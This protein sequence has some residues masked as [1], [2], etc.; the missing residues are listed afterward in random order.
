MIYNC[1][2]NQ[3]QINEL[4]FPI[5]IFNNFFE[6]SGQF[7]NEDEKFF[8]SLALKD[9]QNVNK[10]S[11]TIKEKSDNN[12]YYFTYKLRIALTNYIIYNSCEEIKQFT[13]LKRLNSLIDKINNNNYLPI[14]K[15]EDF[16]SLIS[17][18]NSKI[19]NN[20]FEYLENLIDILSFF[21]LYLLYGFFKGYS[22]YQNSDNII[23]NL[24]NL[25]LSLYNLSNI[26]ISKKIYN[27][28]RILVLFSFFY[29][30]DIYPIPS[31]EYFSLY[32]NQS[33][34][35]INRN[36]FL[37]SKEIK[38]SDLDLNNKI[39]QNDMILNIFD[40]TGNN[41]IL[42][43]SNIHNLYLILMS[44]F[45]DQY[46]SFITKKNKL[47]LP[48]NPFIKKLENNTHLYLLIILLVQSLNYNLDRL[49]DKKIFK[50]ILFWDNQ[51]KI[52]APNK[53]PIHYPFPTKIINY[54]NFSKYF[55]LDNF[56]TF[57][58]F[59]DIK[60]PLFLVTYLHNFNKLFSNKLIFAHKKKSNLDLLLFILKNR[61]N[62]LSISSSFSL[63]KNDFY[64]KP[65]SNL[66]QVITII[67]ENYSSFISSLYLLR[68]LFPI[69]LLIIED[70]TEKKI[71]TKIY[72]YDCEKTYI[73]LII[74]D[75]SK[76]DYKEKT[77]I[78]ENYFIALS[79]FLERIISSDN[80]Y[81][82]EKDKS[83]ENISKKT[84]KQ[85]Y[86]SKM[87]YEVYYEAEQEF[88]HKN[89]YDIKIL[90]NAYYK[91][92]NLDRYNFFSQFSELIYYCIY[93]SILEIKHSLL[94]YIEQKKNEILDKTNK[95]EK[96]DENNKLIQD[97]ISQ[98][99]KI[100][101]R[102]NYL[103]KR[104]EEQSFYLNFIH[105]KGSYLYIQEIYDKYSYD[106][107]NSYRITR[108]QFRENL[109]RNTF[110]EWIG[111]N[112][113]KYNYIIKSHSTSFVFSKQDKIEEIDIVFSDV[114]NSLFNPEIVNKYCSEEL[115]RF[116]FER[117]DEDDEEDENKYKNKNNKIE[118]EKEQFL[119]DLLII[120]PKK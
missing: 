94:R 64:I 8:I 101:E 24:Y 84:N 93:L 66:N 62:N 83:K 102:I 87:H 4:I 38:N 117:Y 11:P 55:F 15:Y 65:E 17:F 32:M 2:L 18:F 25:L 118:K 90:E 47:P 44:K 31:I 60:D 49:F 22:F 109:Y 79:F 106:F 120:I 50:N 34:S 57:L 112:L 46:F 41:F 67:K 116:L 105:Y 78:A 12:L 113:Q 58:F 39:H 91:N 89:F 80:Y 5:F 95:T 86:I 76:Y 107:K 13:N 100:N 51:F 82:F 10:I 69:I 40:N 81:N 56:L 42:S 3:K 110:F 30:F 37:F 21:S 43:N 115:N 9:I 52:F 97:K 74:P 59:E 48:N 72:Q 73:N 23:E 104:Y 88:S 77:S 63:S 26:F 1:N 27:K 114:E 92:F 16:N 35:L 53:F 61:W 75:L 29:I 36:S 103:I 20:N 54:D 6:L 14:P 33:V 70:I 108:F 71:Q 111:N 119:D 45:M 85:N 96:D 28:E 99:T 68:R 19:T 98:L 7:L